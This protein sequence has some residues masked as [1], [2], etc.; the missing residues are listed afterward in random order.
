MRFVTFEVDG[1]PRPGVVTGTD[2]VVDLSPA[3]FP[4][5]L[6]VIES[7]DAGRTKIEKY[8]SSVP[9]GAKLPLAKTRLLAPIPIPRKLICVGLNYLDHAKESGS[10]IPNVPT[11][12][13][14]FA[15][16]VIGPGATIV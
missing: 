16:S 13:N 4:S 1:Q 10:E 11:I 9:Q 14:K 2:S 15:T 5:L 7:G 8:L 3:G 6:D 12:F